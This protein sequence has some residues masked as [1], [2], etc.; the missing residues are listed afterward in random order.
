[1]YDDD[2]IKT[3]LVAVVTYDL[4]AS[5]SNAPTQGNVSPKRV[6]K[7]HSLRKNFYGNPASIGEEKKM[8]QTI[9]SHSNQ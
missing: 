3:H 4:R 2:S 6:W 5:S 9:L 8:K 7:D 1:M